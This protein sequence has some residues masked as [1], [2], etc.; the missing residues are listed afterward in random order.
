MEV[1][2]YQTDDKNIFMYATQYSA[3]PHR[4]VC[5]PPPT[6]SEGFA[7]IWET[8]LDPVADMNWGSEG[9]GVWAVEADFRKLDLYN[10]SDGSKFEFNANY[11]GIGPVPS[12]LTTIARP[13]DIYTWQNGAWYAD[14]ADIAAQE[15]QVALAQ[16]QATVASERARADA[17]IAPLQDAV[18]GGYADTGDADLLTAWKRYRY[19]LT[20]V[21]TQ[22]GYPASIDWPTAPDA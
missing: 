12:W 16:A 10:T 8:T 18:D 20:K 19:D 4:G 7:A 22:A 9:T 15:N 13:S 5:V 2:Y 17:T 21:S 11:A 14:P 6:T 1:T 3:K